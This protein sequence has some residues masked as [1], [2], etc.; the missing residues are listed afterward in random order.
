MQ[1]PLVVF[2]CFLLISGTAYVSGAFQY[3]EQLA[4]R[5][6]R[7]LNTEYNLHYCGRKMAYEEN[8]SQAIGYVTRVYQLNDETREELE[9]WVETN[10]LPEEANT[11][12]AYEGDVCWSKQ[13]NWVNILHRQENHLIAND[14]PNWFYVRRPRD[15]ARVH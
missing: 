3:L 4:S 12:V 5:I 8:L 7:D 13:G 11:E 2:S 6:Q 9:V 15:G 14:M 10:Y 1:I